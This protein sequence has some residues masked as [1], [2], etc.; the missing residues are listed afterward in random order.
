MH[1]IKTRVLLTKPEVFE[2]PPRGSSRL[3]EEKRRTP[4]ELLCFRPAEL[5]H[6][7][8]PDKVTRPSDL[9]SAIQTSGNGGQELREQLELRQQQN[10]E[11]RSNSA[12]AGMDVH[13]CKLQCFVWLH[14]AGRVMLAMS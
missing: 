11:L 13:A 10:E 6:N 5:G 7:F 3:R 8:R 4:H 2:Q 14:W 1:L 12:K 9:Q